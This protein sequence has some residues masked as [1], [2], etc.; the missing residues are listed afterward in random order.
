MSM[1]NILLKFDYE[2][3]LVAQKGV[4]LEQYYLY[5]LLVLVR[6]LN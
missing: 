1:N 6:D 5:C 2:A 3:Y 4:T